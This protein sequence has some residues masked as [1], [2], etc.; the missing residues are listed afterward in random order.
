MRPI[1]LNNTF[2][3]LSNAINDSLNGSLVNNI[4]GVLSA[5]RILSGA[6]TGTLNGTLSGSLNK[7]L[8]ES[9]P[10]PVA[11]PLSSL[12]HSFVHYQQPMN[13]LLAGQ[14]NQFTNENAARL[15]QIYNGQSMFNS[16]LLSMLPNVFPDLYA[17]RPAAD[18]FGAYNQQSQQNAP[19][20]PKADLPI[21]FEHL[22]NSDE[23]KRNLQA[24]LNG[25]DGMRGRLVRENFRD[26]FKSLAELQGRQSILADEP[27]NC[28]ENRLNE[29]T[30]DDYFTSNKKA[31]EPVSGDRLSNGCLDQSSDL[32]S[33]LA[34]DSRRPNARSNDRPTEPNR[35]T[36]NSMGESDRVDVLNDGQPNK[37]DEEITIKEEGALKNRYLNGILAQLNGAD[38]SRSRKRPLDENDDFAA[39]PDTAEPAK[40]I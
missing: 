30:N 26:N 28:M 33:D 36:C 32:A 38:N 35:L 5:D 24:E 25:G 3:T 8:N 1:S 20:R 19:I 6:L 21:T 12:Q 23:I 18:L 17:K 4:G 2:N 39:R 11:A 13:S 31:G 10:T 37:S 34:S 15:S 9:S 29:R 7:T 22:L 14:Q 27:A 16:S 40:K